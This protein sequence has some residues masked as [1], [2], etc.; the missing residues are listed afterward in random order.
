MRRVRKV[1]VLRDYRL[2]LEFDDGVTGTVDLSGLVGKGVF[3]IWRDYGAFEQVRIG[4]SGEL[5]WQEKV[6]LCPDALYLKVTGKKP[7]EVFPA[8]HDEPANA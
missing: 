6:D 2:E 5:A 8:L 3:S 1:K 7:E 4:P